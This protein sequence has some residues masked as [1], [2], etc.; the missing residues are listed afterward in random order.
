MATV[1]L[2]GAM[3][4]PAGWIRGSC[5]E[6]S[7]IEGTL[8]EVNRQAL[9]A[10]L[11]QGDVPM[12]FPRTLDEVPGYQGAKLPP[13]MA[14]PEHSVRV[15]QVANLEAIRATSSPA[16]VERVPQIRVT[17]IPT[18]GAFSAVIPLPHAE[19]I[20]TP[21]WVELRLRVLTGEVAFGVFGA[22]LNMLARTPLSIIK[23]AEPVDVAVKIPSL[24][25]A[26][27]I[28]IFNASNLV[29]AQVDVLDAAVLVSPQDF[30]RRPGR[31][32]SSK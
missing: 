11:R 29:G 6:I 8:A 24:E 23:T 9:I 12:Q 13:E 25:G 19:T 4:E 27:Q 32:V 1:L 3:R 21:C 5:R 31:L 10:K 15:E 18:V 14:P 28:I 7:S 30:E 22:R 2:P 17:T 16:R 26:T 20:T